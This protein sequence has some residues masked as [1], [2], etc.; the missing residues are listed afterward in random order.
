M[1]AS[2]LLH[3][4]DGNLRISCASQYDRCDTKR[5]IRRCA[6]SLVEHFVNKADYWNKVFNFCPTKT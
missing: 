1:A 4:C 3:T 6:R 2:S 5:I